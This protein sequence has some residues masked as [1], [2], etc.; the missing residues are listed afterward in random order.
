[1]GQQ[2]TGQSEPVV[3]RDRGAERKSTLRRAAKSGL[4]S[5][6][7]QATRPKAGGRGVYIDGRLSVLHEG[8]AGFEAAGRH[9]LIRAGRIEIQKNSTAGQACAS[10]SPITSKLSAMPEVAD[11]STWQSENRSVVHVGEKQRRLTS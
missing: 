9:A 2:R 11:V 10:A 1:M 6:M 8:A 5:D 7:E 4:E 3:M